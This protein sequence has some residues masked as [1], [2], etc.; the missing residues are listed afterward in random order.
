[1]TE[2]LQAVLVIGAGPNQEPLIEGF[3]KRGLSIVVVDRDPQAP[4]LVLA[5]SVIALSTH[6]D[7]A[8]VEALRRH[9]FAQ[10]LVAVACPTTGRPYITAAR[11]AETLGLPF[12]N[13]PAVETM[14]EKHELWRALKS[15]GLSQRSCSNVAPGEILTGID[16][17]VVIKPAQGGGASEGVSFC[18]ASEELPSAIALAASQSTN[19]RALVES[20]LAGPEHKIAGILRCGKL[21]LLLVG[22]RTFGD[23]ARRLPIA[24][25]LGRTESRPVA[26]LERSLREP[27]TTLCRHLGLSDTPLN[28]DVINEEII[29]FDVSLGSMNHLLARAAGIDPVE[30]LMDLTLRLPTSLERRWWR[31]SATTYLWISGDSLSSELLRDRCK[32][33]AEGL[34]EPFLPDPWIRRVETL[35]TETPIRV[36]GLVTEGSTQEEALKRGS[37]WLDEVERSLVGHGGD[38]KVLH[39]GEEA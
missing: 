28:V 27:L 1:M 34:G 35:S 29:D 37:E 6:D 22:Q 13:L 11:C 38:P 4:G 24:V 20:F 26:A 14:L 23:D 5:D 30:T 15:L 9:P 12:P 8:V 18:S 36:G 31:G 19:G 39:P 21:E 3:S 32:A 2:P 25:A 7:E 33:A 16:L 10:R 17:P